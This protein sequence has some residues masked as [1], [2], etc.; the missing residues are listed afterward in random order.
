MAISS[1]F[2]RPYT[3]SYRVVSYEVKRLSKTRNLFIG[4]TRN[5]Y[6]WISFSALTVLL[7]F[8]VASKSRHNGCIGLTMR[9]PV[10]GEVRMKLDHWLG[11]PLCFFHCF[12]GWQVGHPTHK[13]IFSS[14]CVGWKLRGCGKPR[15]TC[16]TAFK[17]ELGSKFTV[18]FEFNSCSLR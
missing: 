17:T 7:P 14:T 9:S 10:L 4:I 2:E 6:E 11:S 16:K 18:S 15:F 13:K 5:F 8:S 12:V 1:A 3:V